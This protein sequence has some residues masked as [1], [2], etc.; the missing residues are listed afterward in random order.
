MT[1]S[2]VETISEEEIGKTS[3]SNEDEFGELI[4]CY[5]YGRVSTLWY[6]RI[7]LD[8][9]NNGEWSKKIF[10]LDENVDGTLLRENIGEGMN[11]IIVDDIVTKAFLRNAKKN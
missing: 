4:G 3:Q 5:V 9:R 8:I 2:N 10:Q 11:F 6:K 1:E 7:E